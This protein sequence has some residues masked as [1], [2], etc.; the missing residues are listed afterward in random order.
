[1]NLVLFGDIRFWQVL[2]LGPSVP[3]AHRGLFFLY[4]EQK[5]PAAPL[6]RDRETNHPANFAEAPTVV[7]AAAN[8]KVA[9]PTMSTCVFWVA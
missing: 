3:E 9:A 7:F 5:K 8:R 6:P 4:A 2:K 1:M